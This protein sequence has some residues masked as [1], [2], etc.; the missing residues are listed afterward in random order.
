MFHTGQLRR[1]LVHT[2]MSG[3]KAS[4]APDNL[5]NM[6][7][8]RMNMMAGE[9]NNTKKQG[10]EQTSGNKY[11]RAATAGKQERPRNWSVVSWSKS[12]S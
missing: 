2:S 6:S 1:Y 8:G 11:A 3:T 4:R 12:I 10:W 5:A 7:K 9:V